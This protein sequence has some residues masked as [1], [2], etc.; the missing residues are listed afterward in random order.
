VVDWASSGRCNCSTWN[1]F[2]TCRPGIGGRSAAGLHCVCA[3]ILMLQLFHVEQ[4]CW[5]IHVLVRICE[6]LG[7]RTYRRVASF[8]RQGG[9]GG[10]GEGVPFRSE[11][12][13]PPR[14]SRGVSRK[15]RGYQDNS[16]VRR[17]MEMIRKWMGARSNERSC[18]AGCRN[19]L[20]RRAFL[21]TNPR[22][23]AVG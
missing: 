18:R 10:R 13:R 20:D 17:R 22:E 14:K 21:G 2:K 4:L 16:I 5:R 8:P 9:G 1:N 6:E 19:L 15:V 12:G 23:L 11:P 7:C 3:I